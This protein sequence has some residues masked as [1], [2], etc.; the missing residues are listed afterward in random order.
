MRSRKLTHDGAKINKLFEQETANAKWGHSKLMRHAEPAGKEQATRH[1]REACGVVL[2]SAVGLDPS[3]IDARGGARRKQQVHLRTR[4][5]HSHGG[6]GGRWAQT[7]LKGRAYFCVECRLLGRTDRVSRPKRRAVVACLCALEARL[8]RDLGR[9][10]LGLLGAW[11]HVAST[12]HRVHIRLRQHEWGD[13]QRRLAWWP[14]RG[15]LGRDQRGAVGLE[16]VDGVLLE[17]ERPAPR[18]N[19]TRRDGTR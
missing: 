6:T 15:R 16:V 8:R 3:Q 4:H 1:V 12:R 18:L 19:L 14:G 9:R 2:A 13:D 17:G 10:C 7:Q 5:G 11:R